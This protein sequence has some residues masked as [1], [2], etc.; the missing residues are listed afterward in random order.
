MEPVL[1]LVKRTDKFIQYLYKD[2]DDGIWICY[3]NGG[4]EILQKKTDFYGSNEIFFKQYNVQQYLKTKET[5][6]GLVQQ[7]MASIIYLQK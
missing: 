7:I 1:K 6:Y 2:K 5:E 4:A 3:R